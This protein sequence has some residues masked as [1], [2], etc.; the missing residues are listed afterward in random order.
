MCKFYLCKICGN[1]IEK[2]EDSGIAPFCCAKKMSLLDPQENEVAHEKHVPVATVTQL[3]QL[4]L[5]ASGKVAKL[6]HIE[7]G[8][9]PHPSLNNHYIKWI[10]LVTDKGVYRRHLEPGAKPEADF[11]LCDCEKTL[12]VYAYCNLH[13]LWVCKKCQN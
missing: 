13:G 7:V 12:Q 1:I 6:V 11:I 10:Q 5:D 3:P 9:V 2:V 8:S 4:T